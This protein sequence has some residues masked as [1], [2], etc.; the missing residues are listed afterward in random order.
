MGSSILH[1]TRGIDNE[2]YITS[3]DEAPKDL[4]NLHL[5]TLISNKL[6]DELISKMTIENTLDSYP[7]NSDKRFL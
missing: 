7:Q 3:L 2:I 5:E 4:K 6:L 1:I